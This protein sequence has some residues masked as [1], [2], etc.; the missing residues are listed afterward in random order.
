VEITPP[1]TGGP[2]IGELPF[3]NSGGRNT[4]GTVASLTDGK[5][6]YILKH[7]RIPKKIRA[8]TPDT[9]VCTSANRP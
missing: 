1:L 4:G 8:G 6:H 9:S 3:C 2:V 7:I 5:D